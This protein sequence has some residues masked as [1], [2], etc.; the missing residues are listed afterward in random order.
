MAKAKDN[1]LLLDKKLSS[2]GKTWKKA[3]TVDASSNFDD[4]DV[5]DGT[6]EARI[7]SAKIGLTAKEDVTFTI[8]LQIEGGEYNDTKV[9]VFHFL[10]AAD[11]EEMETKCAYLA[12]DLKRA[13]YELEENDVNPLDLKEI[14]AHM[15]EAKQLLEISTKQNEG[16]DGKMRLN[17][18]INKLA[19]A[20]NDPAPTTKK[21][22]KK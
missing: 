7:V 16:K 19:G 13:G 6:Y 14:A 17:V 4:P 5:P 8:R 18:Y 21:K 3:R 20:T 9:R 11:E 12:K 2:L 10:A 15:T 1:V 22:A